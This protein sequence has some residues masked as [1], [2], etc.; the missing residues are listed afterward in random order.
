[1]QH[2]QF[3]FEEGRACNIFKFLGQFSSGNHERVVELT[4]YLLITR[5]NTTGVSMQLAFNINIKYIAF[6]KSHCIAN[7]Q[8]A[9][10]QKE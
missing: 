4:M 10:V 2:S 1:M 3:L 7:G 5:E 8:N 6:G 9:M